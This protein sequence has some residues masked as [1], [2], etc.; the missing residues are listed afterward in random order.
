MHFQQMVPG[1]EDPWVAPLY[2]LE[3]LRKKLKVIGIQV[4]LPAIAA[5]R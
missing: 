1:G 2:G 3:S 4:T 5:M